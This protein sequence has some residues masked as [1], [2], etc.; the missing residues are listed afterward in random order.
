MSKFR[1]SLIALATLA[2][3][4]CSDSDEPNLTPDEPATPAV[5]ELNRN[6]LISKTEATKA[7]VEA[8]NKFFGMNL[9]AADVKSIEMQGDKWNDYGIYVVTFDR[10]GYAVVDADSLAPNRVMGL[11]DTGSCPQTAVLYASDVKFSY[12]EETFDRIWSILPDCGTLLTEKSTSVSWPTAHWSEYA[13]YNKYCPLLEDG[14]LPPSAGSMAVAMAEVMA[15][16]RFPEKIGDF[17]INWKEMW[18]FP[19]PDATDEV[20]HLLAKIGEDAGFLYH[21]A[22]TYTECH[23]IPDM[24][25]SFGYTYANRTKN[26]SKVAKQT[27]PSI[28]CIKSKWGNYDCC[29][30]TARKSV[31]TNYESVRVAGADKGQRLW[32]TRDYL[33]FE[34]TD[35]SNY[36]WFLAGNTWMLESDGHVNDMF[37]TVQDAF[38]VVD[39]TRP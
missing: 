36:G 18:P 28:G 34:F 21:N 32:V 30:V 3:A 26:M 31:E 2:M 11:S 20:A 37:G 15:Y 19:G 25:K 17:E 24:L 14:K 5:P 38:F 35:G 39:I 6:G 8:V 27:S 4:A 16:H 12:S 7:A 23:D 10:G 22:I 33:K 9:S 1:L 13:P 29:V